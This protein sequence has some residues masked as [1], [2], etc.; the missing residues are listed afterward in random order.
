MLW[1]GQV[2]PEEFFSIRHNLRVIKKKDQTRPNRRAC[3]L[4]DDVLQNHSSQLSRSWKTKTDG[5]TRG[6]RTTECEEGSW[7]PSG[8]EK[9]PGEKV[10]NPEG[11]PAFGKQCCPW[12]MVIWG[13]NRRSSHVKGIWHYFCNKYFQIISSIFKSHEGGG[14]NVGVRMACY[15]H[16]LPRQALALPTLFLS[17]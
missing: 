3:Y 16:F 8:P 2:T 12:F 4:T 11:S 17:S 6:D 14:G 15:I 5:R 9:G 10:V 13:I 7:V 1:G